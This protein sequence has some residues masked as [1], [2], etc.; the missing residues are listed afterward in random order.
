M[1]K[2]SNPNITENAQKLSVE[3]RG[4]LKNKRSE[5]RR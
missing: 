4:V 3:N 1:Q 2:G 5:E